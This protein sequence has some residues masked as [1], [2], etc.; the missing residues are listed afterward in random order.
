MQTSRYDDHASWFVSYSALWTAT[1]SPFLPADLSGTRVLDLACGWGSLSR[2]LARRG[3]AVTGVELALPLL[4]RGRELERTAPQGITYL[5]GD[6]S[7]LD[8]WDRRPF[9]ATVCNMA[10]M[11]IDDLDAT[12]A[13]I[14]AVLRPGG[15]FNVSLL[16]PCYPGEQQAG[17]LS[18][19]PPDTGY[20]TEGWWTTGSTGVRATSAP[21]TASSRPTSTP[22]W[23]PTWNSPDSPNPTRRCR[24]SWSSTDTDRNNTPSHRRRPAKATIPSRCAVS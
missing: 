1:S 11:D 9:D 3:A 21:S 14:R 6:A 24:A 15:W 10:L 23:P 17:A 16:H 8:W 20:G 19:W 18:S 5:H 7:R 12:L 4:E 22:S 2:D 13:T